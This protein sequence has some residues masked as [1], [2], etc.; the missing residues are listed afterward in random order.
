MEKK[1]NL[2]CTKL[3][4]REDYDDDDDGKRRQLLLPITYLL[5]VRIKMVNRPLPN[6]TFTRIVHIGPKCNLCSERTSSAV[7]I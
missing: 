6:Y 4:K 1:R 3:E 5:Y 7:K 2:D